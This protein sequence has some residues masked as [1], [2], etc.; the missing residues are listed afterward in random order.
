[1]ASTYELHE[2]LHPRVVTEAYREE[3]G[4]FF[5]NPL[6]EFY[7]KQIRNYTG[8]R[9]EFAYRAAMHEPAPA[10][11]RGQPAR[12]LQPTGLAERRVY[13]LHAFNEVSLSMDALQMLRRPEDRTP[14]EKGREEIQRQFEDFGDRHLLFRAVALA[15][16][17]TDGVIHFAADGRILESDAAAAY[18]VDFG[19]SDSH[20]GQLDP[21]SGAILDAPW[22]DP[23]AKILDHLDAIRVQAEIEGGG[24][25]RHLWLH[26]SV[27]RWLRENLQLRDYLE[28]SPEKVD[29]A[30]SGSMIEDLAGW[31][32]HFFSGVYQAADGSL[33]SFL[34]P[35]KAVITP[36]LGPWLR[37][38]NGSELLTGFEGIRSSVDEALG[39]IT[40]VF[41]DFAY[42]KLV[43]NPTKLVL[44]MGTNFVYAFANPAAVWMPTIDF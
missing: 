30:L 39:E 40:E 3:A 20:R 7:G 24:E 16:T 10:N 31:T 33:A 8:D 37:A 44:R 28:G 29:R 5:T 38:A 36:D 15:K 2:I 25:P 41:G 42:V 23:D 32:W 13:M 21:G 4:R 43:D 1:M 17:L 22:D 11:L 27:K 26:H 9:F 19:V 14:M 18:S 12:V 34:P 35:T 6:V